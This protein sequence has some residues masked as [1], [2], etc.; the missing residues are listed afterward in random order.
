[1]LLQIFFDAIITNP[2]YSL[3]D[4]FLERCYSFGKFFALLM[5]LTALEGKKRNTLYRKYGI[6]LLVFDRRVEFLQETKRRVWFESRLFFK[7]LSRTS[8]VLT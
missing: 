3:K 7:E 5:P 1:M 8:P 6:N 2:P 4:R